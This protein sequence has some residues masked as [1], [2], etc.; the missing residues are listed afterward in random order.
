VTGVFNANRLNREYVVQ[1]V[2]EYV[3]DYHSFGLSGSDS[4][5]ARRSLPCCNW[6][7]VCS[8]D[9]GY[10]CSQRQTAQLE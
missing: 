4:E 1:Y 7:L 10:Q 6:A 8:K 5:A 2:Y 9:G 3:V